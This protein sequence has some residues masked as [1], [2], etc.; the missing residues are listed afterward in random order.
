MYSQCIVRA[1]TVY[2]CLVI[3]HV[4]VCVFRCKSCVYLCCVSHFLCPQQAKLFQATKRQKLRCSGEQQTTNSLSQVH[5]TTYMYIYMYTCNV[6]VY[7][8]S[9]IYFIA[10]VVTFPK[11]NELPQVGL[12]P[13]TLY[14]L[15]RALYH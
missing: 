14:T 6:H 13:T 11:K 1:C 9:I 5:C 4:H 8:C 12:E 2:N 10:K 7:T 15:D 3:I